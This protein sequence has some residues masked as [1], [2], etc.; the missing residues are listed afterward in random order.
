MPAPLSL[1]E[2]PSWQQQ[3]PGRDE[4]PHSARRCCKAVAL[5]AANVTRGALSATLAAKPAAACPG[6]SAGQEDPHHSNKTSKKYQKMFPPHTRIDP[7]TREISM[8]NQR[9]SRMDCHG[10]R[11]AGVWEG[12]PRSSPVLA[13]G[14]LVW[15]CP[16]PQLS[17]RPA[18]LYGLSHCNFPQHK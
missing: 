9:R 14:G 8:K 4:P 10:T 5:L 16:R 13:E 12:G 6:R 7:K 3:F 15:K 2:L 17:S 1:A 11:P 18:C